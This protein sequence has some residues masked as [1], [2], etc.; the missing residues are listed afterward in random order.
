MNPADGPSAA[1]RE[2]GRNAGYRR[3]VRRR[4]VAMAAFVLGNV[5]VML[6]LVGLRVDAAVGGPAVGSVQVLGYGLSLA[7]LGWGTLGWI[8]LAGL[9][10]F[11]SVGTAIKTMLKAEG[12]VLLHPSDADHS[13]RIGAVTGAEVVGIVHEM[14]SALG[15]GKIDSVALVDEAVPNAFTASAPGGGAV[16]VVHSNLLEV[17]PREAVRAVIAHEVGHIRRRDSIVALLAH[18]PK[19]IGVMLG[20]FAVLG[21]L[22]GLYHA[23]WGWVLVERGL[24]LAS[25]VAVWGV[26]NLVLRRIGARASRLGEHLADAHAAAVCGW[27]GHVSALLLIGER[28][29]ALGALAASV[30]DLPGRIGD[31]DGARHLRAV[32]ARF[33]RAEVDEAVAAAIAPRIFV[34]QRLEALRDGLLVP[35]TDE[36]ILELS[37]RAVEALALKRAEEAATAKKPTEAP[38]EETDW[39]DFDADA[40][41][42]LDAAEASRL[43]AALRAAPSRLLF[44]HT[45]AAEDPFASHPPLRERI[46]AVHDLFVGGR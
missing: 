24:F 23:G 41:G 15:V 40:S 34:Q 46:L 5:A 1:I 36:Q 32:V 38:F 29:E 3:L 39:R 28:M 18:A 45:T 37:K 25:A 11:R 30:Q 35:L 19:Y 16:V 6:L 22:D 12:V 20:G 42:T 43:V 13:R 7:P 4:D 14:A 9:I 8:A 2:L 33:P 17:L 44:S 26:V 10:V 27:E 31:E 21:L